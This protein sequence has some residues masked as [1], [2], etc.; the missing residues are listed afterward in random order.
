MSLQKG[1]REDAEAKFASKQRKVQEARHA[2]SDYEANVRHVDE[3]T[4]RLKALRLA[5]EA[6]DDAAPKPKKA[7]A[8]KRAVKST[9][10]AE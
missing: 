3:N 5:K 4:A 1:S 6:A 9:K 8:R 10:K 7:P 2:M